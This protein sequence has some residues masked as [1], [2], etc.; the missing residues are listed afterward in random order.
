MKRAYIAG[1]K[2]AE[3]RLQEPPTMLPSARNMEYISEP[4]WSERVRTLA[5]TLDLASWPEAS[6]LCV[7]EFCG[8]GGG[9]GFRFAQRTA[10]SSR[11][12]AS[13]GD[14]AEPTQDDLRRSKT[15]LKFQSHSFPH[16]PV[17][18]PGLEVTP[19]QMALQQI[20]SNRKSPVLSGN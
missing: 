6:R 13:G 1:R 7:E 15:S 12:S 10:N 4:R 2:L 19:L 14:F 16:D 11:V 20:V 8:Q 3:G 18:R 9:Q 5:R 17:S